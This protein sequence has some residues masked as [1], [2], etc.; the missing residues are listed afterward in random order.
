MRLEQERIQAKT[1][2]I[3]ERQAKDRDYAEIQ[4]FNR[5]F[6][7]DEEHTYAGIG[8]LNSSLNSSMDLSQ[9]PG[10]DQHPQTPKDQPLPLDALYAQVNK[11]RNGRPPSTDSNRLAPSNHDRILRLRQEFQQVKHEDGP[12]DRRHSYSFQ[13]QPWANTPTG[14]HSVSVEVQV[15]RQRE[16]RDSFTQAQRQYN[17]LPRPQRKNPSIVSQDSWEKVYPPGEGFQTAKENPRYSS[18]QGSRATNGYIG[19]VS[20]GMNARVLLETQELLRQ[21]QRRKEQEAKTKLPAMQEMPAQPPSQFPA[22]TT[23]KGPYRQDVPP[24]PTQLA[25]LNRIQ[26]PEMGHN[27]YS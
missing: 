19:T 10:Q 6:S 20:T 9:N 5:N 14:R 21:E 22:P 12:G 2:E 8:S 26:T 11:S 16:D 13:Q 18:Y 7:S 23:P 4:D 3:R 1:R 15:Q 25:R 17:S 27:F 24:S